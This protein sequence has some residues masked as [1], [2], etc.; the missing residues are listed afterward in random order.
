MK[1]IFISIL[2]FTIFINKSNGF[3]TSYFTLFNSNEDPALP[4]PTTLSTL[5]IKIQLDDS[6]NKL[7]NDI[8]Y[9][10]ILFKR[11]IKN[12]NHTKIRVHIENL[13][14]IIHKSLENTEIHEDDVKKLESMFDLINDQLN[15][16][17]IF[18]GKY[19]IPQ[20]QD[21]LTYVEKTFKCSEFNLYSDIPS[22]FHK[23][24]YFTNT[25]SDRIEEMVLQKQ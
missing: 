12:I 7:F 10:L 18:Y 5:G 22:V 25:L 21:A 3:S 9:L 17:K 15:T 20:L 19:S 13:L 4:I 23:F 1:L 8:E 6:T 14:S 24:E 11:V 2:A 16:I